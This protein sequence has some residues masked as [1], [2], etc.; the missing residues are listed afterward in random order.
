MG[1]SCSCLNQQEAAKSKHS[2]YSKRSRKLTNGSVNIESDMYQYDMSSASDNRLSHQQRSIN[3][4]KNV[5]F[6]D[7]QRHLSEANNP[8][9]TI[10]ESGKDKEY[11]SDFHIIRQEQHKTQVEFPIKALGNSEIPSF[12]Y[13]GQ[14]QPEHVKNLNMQQDLQNSLQQA[15]DPKYKSV[16]TQEMILSMKEKD[17][18][19]DKKNNTKIE[20][21]IRQTLDTENLD[22]HQMQST[23]T[24]LKNQDT[25]AGIFQTLAQS[26]KHEQLQNKSN[27][28]FNQSEQDS[29]QLEIVNANMM[30]T[31]D[32]DPTQDNVIASF[33]RDILLMKKSFDVN[34][35][36]GFS[37]KNARISDSQQSQFNNLQSPT[38]PKQ[39]SGFSSDLLSSIN[40]MLKSSAVYLGTDDHKS[41]LQNL[42]DQFDN[43]APLTLNLQNLDYADERDHS[44]LDDQELLE[45][46]K[47]QVQDDFPESP[48]KSRKDNNQ[49]AFSSSQV[50]DLGS[51][52]EDDYGEEIPEGESYKS[53]NS[54]EIHKKSHQLNQSFY[55]NAS[56]VQIIRLESNGT[57][58]SQETSI[59]VR[60]IDDDSDASQLNGSLTSIHKLDNFNS[61]KNQT[62]TSIYSQ[63]SNGSKQQT[64][65]GNLQGQ[66]IGNIF[67][68]Q[69]MNE[70]KL[71]VLQETS[72]SGNFTGNHIPLIQDDSI[73]YDEHDEFGHESD[74]DQNQNLQ[75]F[76]KQSMRQSQIE[77]ST[78]YQS[79]DQDQLNLKQ[80]NIINMDQ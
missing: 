38:L 71:D 48:M 61:G 7:M 8:Y 23:Q 70:L 34:Y 41:E 36:F 14:N 45:E 78:G 35:D 26:I 27:R 57:F 52:Y 79:D 50:K 40:V 63:S 69:F 73:I 55:S 56:S 4:I 28:S 80:I 22:A 18:N 12:A 11:A 2:K 62:N 66:K 74:E 5:K 9:Q 64:A 30:S 42:V 37:K 10:Q 58:M 59:V 17:P 49:S 15:E 43:K 29:S 77:K 68:S 46:L 65:I 51:V 32:R 47:D 39:E 13:H 44:D 25:E 19:S 1:N 60:R 16:I 20:D 6:N 31:N 53:G 3:D 72:H 21:L 24:Y 54:T 76:N 67:N 33:D 75:Q